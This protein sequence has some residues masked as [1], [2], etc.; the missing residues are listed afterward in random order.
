VV[1]QFLA[2]DGVERT[3][4]AGDA[5]AGGRGLGQIEIG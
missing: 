3:R 5:R 4:A 2:A 1:E